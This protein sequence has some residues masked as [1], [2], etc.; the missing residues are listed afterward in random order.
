MQPHITNERAIFTL[1]LNWAVAVGALA[2]P[3]FIG[4]F[5]PKI[6]LPIITFAVMLLLMLYRH[7]STSPQAA[8]CE[9]IQTVCIRTLGYSALL[10][11]IFAV[12]ITKGYITYVYPDEIINPEVPFFA[13][14][15]EAPV[16]VMVCA[17]AMFMGDN[18]GVCRRCVIHY[19]NALERGF[20]GKI[21]SQESRY[22]LR[23]LMLISLLLTVVTWTWFL[24]F[25][26]NVNVNAP[27]AFIFNWVPPIFYG[28]SIIYLSMR[29]FTLW[30]YYYND[31][32]GSA[33]RHGASTTIRYLVL[34]GNNM[35]LTREEDFAD[36]PD[37]NKYDTPAM[38]TMAHTDRVSIDR[39]RKIFSDLSDLEP[40]DF[41][42][43]FMYSSTDISGRCNVKH[44]I[45]C[46]PSKDVI[47]DSALKGKWFSLPQLQ[48]L[49][50]NQELAPMLTT[51]LNRLYTVTMA[52]K[53]YDA[54]GRRLYK[55]KNY[56]PNF[57]LTGICDWEVDFNSPKWLMVARYNEDK[58]FFRL[59][60]M[61]VRR[62]DGTE[63]NA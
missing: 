25:Y 44:F 42:I 47:E 45:C 29:Y 48:R 27:D 43:R 41:T 61:F 30:S 62:K 50:Y 28:L 38:L 39:A 37:S 3:E 6:L 35:M 40:E 33:E 31:I 55:I 56:H 11:L 5:T 18:L 23:F 1:W 26:I 54:Q 63:V 4:L 24:V 7:S 13:V 8:S 57:Q 53:T 49:L 21:F 19:G 20:L 2:L 46:L 9:L 32:E 22:Q 15:I 59:R 34:T 10:M 14:L 52:W 36:M 16:A 17:W 58:P 60:R 51:E 12:I